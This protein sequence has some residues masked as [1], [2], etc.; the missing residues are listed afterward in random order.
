M[1]ILV[2]NDDGIESDGIRRL[3]KTLRER[4]EVWLVAPEGE[5]SG[6]SHSITLRD[7][8]RARSAGEHRFACRGTTA[9]CVI[10]SLLG[11]IPKTNIGEPAVIMAVISIVAIVRLQRR[12]HIGRNILVFVIMLLAYAAQTGFGA[13]LLSSPHD[14]NQLINLCFVLFVTLIVSL[15]RAWSLLKGKH[16]PSAVEGTIP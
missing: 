14:S 4:H 15:E 8:I 3:E 9:D 1:R 12:V 11:L 2:T 13:L 16:L 7:S 5:K 6:A 10:V